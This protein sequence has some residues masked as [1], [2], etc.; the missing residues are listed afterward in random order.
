MVASFFACCA[1]IFYILSPMQMFFDTKTTRVVV[2]KP[3]EKAY[4]LRFR[5]LDIDFRKGDRRVF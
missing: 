3:A 5:F 2:G 1:S 4:F